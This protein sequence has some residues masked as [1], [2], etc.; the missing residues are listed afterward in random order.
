MNYIKI[1]LKN[2]NDLIYTQYL[3]YSEQDKLLDIKLPVPLEI[4][5]LELRFSEPKD[6]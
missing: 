2:D 6:A 4:T 3:A 1:S 5:H